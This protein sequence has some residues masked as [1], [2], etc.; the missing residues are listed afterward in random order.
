MFLWQL[1]SLLPISLLSRHQTPQDWDKLVF[2]YL[3]LLDSLRGLGGGDLRSIIM[4]WNSR[5]DL[6]I[7]RFNQR[8]SGRIRRGLL[9]LLRPL[10]VISPEQLPGWCKVASFGSRERLEQRMQLSSESSVCSVGRLGASSLK[11]WDNR[12]GHFHFR[13]AHTKTL[14]CQD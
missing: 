4:H 14:T 7:Q 9:F 5:T 13:W 6:Q 11:R 3:L 12:V 1:V 10:H 8:P 2:Y